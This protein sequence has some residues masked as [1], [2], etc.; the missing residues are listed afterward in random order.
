MLHPDSENGPDP[1]PGTPPPWREQLLEL[2]RRH[3]E[4]TEAWQQ[5]L[6]WTAELE[7]LDEERQDLEAAWLDRRG[8]KGLRAWWRKLE[9][10]MQMRPEVDSGARVADLERLLADR[11]SEVERLE[12]Q[13]EQLEARL[14]RMESRAEQE[15]EDRAELR[16]VARAWIGEREPERAQRL[17]ELDA[18]LAELE[19]L[20]VG[21]RRCSRDLSHCLSITSQLKMHGRTILASKGS[22]D[23]RPKTAAG[24]VA[25]HAA[26]GQHYTSA[27]GG[28]AKRR[29]YNAIQ[30]SQ[31][32]ERLTRQYER[33]LKVC[34][35]RIVE[36]NTGFPEVLGA[37]DGDDD[38]WAIGSERVARWAS[39]KPGQ[40]VSTTSVEDG[41]LLRRIDARLGL[42]ARL[43][44]EERTAIEDQLE[45][46]LLG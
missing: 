11:T 18:R 21:L 41:L 1:D 15:A 9:R 24:K 26:L 7:R 35:T 16:D 32:I 37:V 20:D 17:R 46:E 19:G 36:L 22:A 5:R 34:A 39:L 6:N 33:E 10:W 4:R 8:S 13:L 25:L 44:L 14:A 40:A 43:C 30:A 45:R 31:K 12:A 2:H 29:A 28:T 3:S 38:L 23:I 42:S 27:I